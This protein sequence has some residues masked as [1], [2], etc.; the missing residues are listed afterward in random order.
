MSWDFGGGLSS[1]ESETLKYLFYD[2]ASNTIKAVRTLET[3][4]STLG[5]G[6]HYVSSGGENIFFTNNTTDVDW[7][8][9][10]TGV[11]DQSVT[12]N[13]DET[14]IIPPTFRHRTSDVL[15]LESNGAVNLAGTP[16]DYQLSSTIPFNAAI[17]GQDIYAGEPIAVDDWLFYSIEDPEGREVYRQTLT[18]QTLAQGDKL[19][20]WFK[21]P[22]E[23]RG[24]TDSMT[25]LWIAKGGQDADRTI[26]KAMPGINNPEQRYVKA[27]Y[28]TFEDYD[29]MS[30][31]IYVD[32]S[33]K[34]RYAATY[35][36]D[37]TIAGIDLTVNSTVGYRSFTVFDAAQS[38]SA[39][40]PCVVKFDE[41]Q[42]DAVLQ[43]K[44]DSY[45][46]YYVPS[47][48]SGSRWRYLDLNTKNGGIV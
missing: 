21:H 5:I 40:K 17:L 6:N 42:G 26:F 28:R 14:G 23:A 34:I 27:Y 8:P 9:A 29:V 11:K 32:A 19:T 1:A 46:F 4:P 44:N 10:W 22:L 20:W 45:L 33:Q 30:G 38:F 35:A 41:G 43:T 48:P 2:E 36:A 3:E 31:V 18:G 7:H 39:A 24:G 12:A 13:Q 16:V 25:K 37:T 47:A 15:S